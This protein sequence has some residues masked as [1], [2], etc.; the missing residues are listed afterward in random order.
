MA[1]RH[2]GP[3]VRCGRV[4]HLRPRDL[5]FICY[6]IPGVREQYQERPARQAR[7]GLGTGKAPRKRSPSPTDALPGTPEKVAVL[8]Q[9]AAAGLLLWHPADATYSTT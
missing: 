5:C 8:E 6:Y 9:R 1:I 3:C 4:K 7:T 2:L